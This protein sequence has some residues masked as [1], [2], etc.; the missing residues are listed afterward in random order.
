LGFLGFFLG[1]GVARPPRTYERERGGG[2][3]GMAI[4]MSSSFLVFGWPLGGGGKRE[5]YPIN[6]S[7]LYKI[8]DWEAM[9]NMQKKPPE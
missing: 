5:P 6:V 1:K 7:L 3:Y 9:T 4:F 8:I 2:R